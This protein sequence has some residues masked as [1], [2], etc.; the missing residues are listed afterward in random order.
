MSLAQDLICSRFHDSKLCGMKAKLTSQVP[1]SGVLMLRH[2]DVDQAIEA[3]AKTYEDR[4]NGGS[5]LQ[6]AMVPCSSRDLWQGCKW[7]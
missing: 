7:S 3:E 5:T 6:S 4:L 1:R 2:I